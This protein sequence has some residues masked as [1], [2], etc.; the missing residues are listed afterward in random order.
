MSDAIRR[1][2]A[3]RARNTVDPKTLK[4]KTGKTLHNPSNGSDVSNRRA[5]ETRTNFKKETVCN[6]NQKC[7]NDICKK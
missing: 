6:K 1:A 3:R 4:M 7:N 5:V 2:K